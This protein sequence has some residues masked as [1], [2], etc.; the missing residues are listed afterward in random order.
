MRLRQWALMLLA[1]GICLVLWYGLSLVT[2]R[3][4]AELAGLA[5]LLLLFWRWRPPPPFERDRK[6]TAEA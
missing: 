6:Q 1:I 2:W 4:V 5:P 3:E